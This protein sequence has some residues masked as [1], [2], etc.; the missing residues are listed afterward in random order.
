MHV[1]GLTAAQLICVSDHHMT[2]IMICK[3]K[4]VNILALL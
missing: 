1:K 4:I 3:F 2:I